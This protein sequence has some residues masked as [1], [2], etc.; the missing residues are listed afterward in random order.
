M[1]GDG[2]NDGPALKAANIGIALGRSGTDVAKDVADIILEEDDL[3]TLIVALRDGRATYSNIRKSVHFFLSTNLSEIM[4]MFAAMALG[5]GFPLNVMQLLW[6]NIISDIFPGLALS[7]ESPEEDILEQPPR[8]A[9][10]PLISSA[11]FKRMASESA[12]ISAGA[13][14]AY[15]LGVRRYG[16]GAAAGSLAFQ[17]LTIGQL[18]HAWSCRSERHSV[19]ERGHE[20]PPNHYLT[21]AVGGSMALQLLTMVVPSLR[22][23]LGLSAMGL[24]DV[25]VAVGTAVLPFLAN[26]GTKTRS[27]QSDAR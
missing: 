6:I 14:L 4:V 27:T 25:A 5:I 21:V 13:L 26:E 24:T 23:A 22:R 12:L 8:R 10:E 17:S 15:G 3:E 19:L 18:L 16:F 9:D 11:D 1:T 7:M 2:I 20:T